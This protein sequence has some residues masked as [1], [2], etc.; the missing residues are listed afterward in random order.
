M[1][2]TTGF[3][4]LGSVDLTTVATSTNEEY[5]D[6]HGTR[7]VVAA[8]DVM[9]HVVLTVKNVKPVGTFKVDSA[10]KDN[11]T[12]TLTDNSDTYGE[13]VDIPGTLIGK[14]VMLTVEMP[15][16]AA[17]S[18]ALTE[19]DT[20]FESGKYYFFQLGR[21]ITATGIEGNDTKT[22]SFMI[23]V[24]E[25][26]LDSNKKLVLRDV[27]KGDETD[28]ESVQEIREILASNNVR[29]VG[30]TAPIMYTF[31]ATGYTAAKTVW[32]AAMRSSIL[33]ASTAGP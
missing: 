6:T 10:N 27:F 5:T 13:D 8:G 7:Y 24:T 12:M 29:K 14:K 17:P 31:T 1:Q 33:R 20:T 19:A 18:R 15:E 3:Y 2:T 25:D 22:L 32:T 26:M 4:R 30:V 23:T 28:C 11:I 21:H 16:D 9:T